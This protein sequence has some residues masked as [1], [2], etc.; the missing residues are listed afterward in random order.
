MDRPAQPPGV[1]V[2]EEAGILTIRF[3]N[4][5]RRNA[6]TPEMRR[7]AARA[8]KAAIAGPTA[9]V[10]VMEGEGGHFSTGADLSGLGDI[11]TLP[12]AAAVEA[13]LAE[14]LDFYRDL[15]QGRLPVIAKV[16]GD[17]FGAGCSLAMA[18]DLV[19]ATP[20][21]RFGMAFGQRGLLPDFG[22]LR[23]L[24]QR[25][26]SHR[27][28][29]MLMFSEVLKGQDAL[30]AGLADELCEADAIDARVAALAADLAHAAPR[31]LAAIREA[32]GLGLAGCADLVAFELP[33][34]VAIS[35]S[36][37]FREGLAAFREKRAPMFT[38]E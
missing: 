26:G 31:P 8:L 38:G 29:R 35:Q 27:A 10:V 5:A 2:A 1:H 9:R 12:D 7:A 28:K 37:D 3:C 24:A 21:A 18:C 30:A 15:A 19:I 20:G 13:R 22:M 17:C 14:A 23:S 16:A 33:A 25:I 32:F 36:R 34:V 11:S 6:F 4:L